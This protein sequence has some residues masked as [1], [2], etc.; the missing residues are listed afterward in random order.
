MNWHVWRGGAGEHS[1]SVG[2]VR[3]SGSVWGRWNERR[4][5]GEHPWGGDRFRVTR[6]ESQALWGSPSTVRAAWGSPEQAQPRGSPIARVVSAVFNPNKRCHRH[7]ETPVSL[8][9]SVPPTG[10]GFGNRQC[11]LQAAAA[12]RDD[13]PVLPATPPARLS[14]RPL[15]GPGLGPVARGEFDRTVGAASGEAG[16]ERETPE[17]SRRQ[18]QSAAAMANR[19]PRGR[20]GSDGTGGRWRRCGGGGSRVGSPLRP[21][22]ARSLAG[23]YPR[24]GCRSTVREGR[25]WGKRSERLGEARRQVPGTGGPWRKGGGSRS[26]PRRG[27]PA[28]PPPP[29]DITSARGRVCLGSPRAAVAPHTFR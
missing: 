28:R 14:P 16:R 6:D 23:R 17:R 4:G 13:H 8:R 18:Q 11:P 3:A 9:V 10:L 24:Q 25:S 29:T 22:E 27:A 5:A 20:A 19:G 26:Q 21:A 2:Q 12:G 1:W 7:Q 15:P